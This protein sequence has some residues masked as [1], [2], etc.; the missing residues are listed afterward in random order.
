MAVTDD[1]ERRVP[2]PAM[3]RWARD[4]WWVMIIVGLGW[5]IIG[6]VVLRADA[7]SLA[8]VG[9]LIGGVLIVAGANEIGLAGMVEGG[10]KFLHYGMA[11]LFLLGGL[12]AFFRPI[13][14]FFALASVLGLILVFYGTF[15]IAR[16]VATRDENPYWWLGLIGGVL[17]LLLAFWVSSSDRVF[18]L[19][20]RA[21][22]ILFWV[23]FMAFVRG[24]SSIMLAFTLKHSGE[25]AAAPRAPVAAGAGAPTVPAEERRAPAEAG[26]TGTA[27]R[28]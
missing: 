4:H 10:W 16:A 6:W 8:T 20:A 23:A 3:M 1:A 18:N 2:E 27:P 5:L 19:A 15:D 11:F 22:L 21:S 9:Y 25:I 12:W 17:L 14:T 28:V 13:G 26:A 24:F 7:T